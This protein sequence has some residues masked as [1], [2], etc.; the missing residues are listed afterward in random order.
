M[1][2][3]KEYLK[4]QIRYKELAKKVR[5]EVKIALIG[6]KILKGKLLGIT[7]YELLIDLLND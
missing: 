7:P 1:K 6:G 3:V 2:V 4:G 5:Q